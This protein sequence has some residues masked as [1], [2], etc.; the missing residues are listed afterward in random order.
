VMGRGG[1]IP[2]HLKGSNLGRWWEM[3]DSIVDVRGR[4]ARKMIERELPIHVEEGGGGEK[5][6]RNEYNGYEFIITVNE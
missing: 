2:V 5:E 1:H 6:S 3:G 4:A